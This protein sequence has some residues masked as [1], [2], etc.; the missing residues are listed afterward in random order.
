MIERLS[1]DRLETHVLPDR[2]ELRFYRD[3]HDR[4]ASWTW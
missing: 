1:I 3:S 4:T 2:F